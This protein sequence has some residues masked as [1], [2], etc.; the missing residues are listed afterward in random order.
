M[1]VLLLLALLAARNCF[2]AI[3]GATCNGTI[4]D[5]AKVNS[6]LSAATVGTTVDASACPFLTTVTISIPANVSLYIN[7]VNDKV[8]NGTLFL[9][10]NGSH[11][12]GKGQGTSTITVANGMITNT[13]VW[14]I[15]Q[16]AS[17]DSGV[18]FNDFTIAG[19]RA[20][21]SGSWTGG[22]LISGPNANVERITFQD[23]SGDG[24]RIYDTG[25]AR[26]TDSTFT[27]TG[28]DGTNNPKAIEGWFDT[29]GTY[30]RF[31]I[32]R[33]HID[34]TATAASGAEG[35]KFVLGN[36]PGITVQTLWE[37][38]NDIF[39]GQSA[40]NGGM[41]I[42]NFASRLD[43]FLTDIHIVGNRCT[44][45][46]GVA[47]ALAWNGDWGISMGGVN[48]GGPLSNDISNNE[49]YNVSFIGIEDTSENTHIVKNSL[50][51]SGGISIDAQNWGKTY[52]AVSVEDNVLL[53][54][55]WTDK[56]V[57]IINSTNGVA[58]LAIAVKNNY[59]YQPHGSAVYVNQGKGA[60][61]I[62]AT[63]T[64]NWFYGKRT[65]SD[66]A[67]TGTTMTSAAANFTSNDVARIMRIQD[68]GG[69]GVALHTKITSVTNSTTATLNDSCTVN[70]SG[71]LAEI[72]NG[73]N[74][75]AI[76]LGSGGGT[77]TN[78]HLFD[79]GDYKNG[80]CGLHYPT[81]TTTLGP[82]DFFKV[83]WPTCT[84]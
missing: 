64:G 33:N 57:Q 72:L 42:E 23:L 78:N 56:S 28:V 9:T 14:L 32:E 73:D 67:C 38:G 55:V 60:G 41:C 13:G 30:S 37:S 46:G 39:V 18:Q 27:G 49:I 22:I 6:A 34:T 70:V 79:W 82:N 8:S 4:D 51:W 20:N 71:K 66:A 68:A 2:A 17:T 61:P 21:N 74:S 48:G 76:I 40:S 24:I 5:G 31:Y 81:A 26:V 3:P 58:M 1:R 47:G 50:V 83:A 11:L 52:T 69:P 53:N 10:H 35:I 80:S 63:V 84:Y 36:Y 19:N 25:G 62:E 16:S 45:H 43:Q 12:Y 54:T 15:S 77:L 7:N 59:F 29:A 44:G 65:V 75:N